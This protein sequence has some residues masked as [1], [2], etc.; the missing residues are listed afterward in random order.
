MQDAAVNRCSAALKGD[1]HSIN[2]NSYSNFAK[3]LGFF[4]EHLRMAVYFFYNGTI[5]CK[6]FNVLFPSEAY[7]EEA[8]SWR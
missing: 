5:G 6:W 1:Y 3:F 4:T 8:I 2:Y 7:L